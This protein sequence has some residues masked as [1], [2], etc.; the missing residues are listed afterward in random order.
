MIVGVPLISPVVGSRFMP[1]GKAGLID[2]ETTVP[3]SNVG[4]TA[5]IEESLVSVNELGS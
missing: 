5:V 1:V 2:H 4:V 3:P